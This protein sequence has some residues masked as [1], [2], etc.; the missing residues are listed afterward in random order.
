[1][2]CLFS[3]FLAVLVL[4]LSGQNRTF[5]EHWQL[6]QDDLIGTGRADLDWHRFGGGAAG[7]GDLDGNGTTEIAVGEIGQDTGRLWILSLDTSGQVMRAREINLQGL[8]LGGQFGRR[9]ESL[10]DWDGDGVID[11]AVAEP[12]ASEVG[13]PDGAVWI[14][15]LKENGT[16]KESIRISRK[17]AA[18][19]SVLGPGTCFGHDV[20]VVGDLDGNGQVDL[21]VGAPGIESKHQGRVWLLLMQDP[22]TVLKAID[23]GAEAPDLKEQLRSGDLFGFSL[24]ALPMGQDW[25]TLAIGAPADDATGLNQGALYL[26]QLQ[27][28][29]KVKKWQKVVNRE[30]GLDVFLAA[31]DRWTS[32]LAYL[33]G[34]GGDS[35]LALAT[36]VYQDDDGRK[37]QG[38]I[39]VVY[40]RGNGQVAGHHKISLVTSNF[41][42][43]FQGLGYYQ[44][45]YSL[46]AGGD[47][48][49][50]GRVD[51]LVNG[52]QHHQ[53]L[54]RGSLWVLR[55]TE[56]PER[57]NQPLEWKAGAFHITAQDSARIY[58]GATTA[59]D[60]LRID[61]LY[62]LSGYA[63]SHII[64]LLDVSASMD[65]SS[66][67]PVLRESFIALLPFL[68]PEDQISVVTYSGSPSISLSAVPA[69]ERDSIARTLA[70]LNSQ[71]GTHPKKALRMAYDLAE[72]HFIPD[73][74]NRI[75]LATDGGFDLRS[76]DRV[77]EQKAQLGIPLSVFYF[78]RLPDWQIN[79]L[80]EIARKGRGELSHI[81]SSS[82]NEA[83]LREIKM[84]RKKA[85]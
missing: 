30:Q 1:M 35:T 62:D 24:E 58:A 57:L 61:S 63:P 34:W 33:P 77:L 59:E 64:F 38:A 66:K 73:G 31:E 13:L 43:E 69:S 85:D 55:P 6:T 51:L 72:A 46:N 68:R 56:W 49:R 76:L 74:N 60:S 78:G 3:L 9:V 44:W 2:R 75:I 28:E 20:A 67:L 17:D 26:V 10:G 54:K 25:P 5:Y 53:P 39:Y 50:D 52:D 70:A 4:S 65:H 22:R 83:L 80:S 23:L 18:L 84:I 7:L 16:L 81:L 11:V 21:A 14:L 40:L 36:G 32:S 71:G 47:L 8:S 42:G 48:D 45:G 79:A 37:N 12:M 15:L 19:R 82:A 29:G 41:E 27:A